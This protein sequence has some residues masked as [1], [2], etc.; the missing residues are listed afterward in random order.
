MGDD[1]AIR[2]KDPN[3][4]PAGALSVMLGIGFSGAVHWGE[5]RQRDW[6]ASVRADHRQRWTP[7]RW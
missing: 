4:N 7:Q 3:S 5:A 1:A 2:G 6:N